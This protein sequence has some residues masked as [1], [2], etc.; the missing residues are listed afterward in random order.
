MKKVFVMAVAIMLS[1][2]TVTMAQT[3]KPMKKRMDST[4]TMGKD[5]S[6]MNHKMKPMKKKMNKPMKD[7]MM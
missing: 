5:T 7:S 4:M 3:K 2:A 6:M 1:G